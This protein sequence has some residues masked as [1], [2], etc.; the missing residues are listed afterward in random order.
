MTTVHARV[1]KCHFCGVP[2]HTIL[3]CNDPRIEDTISTFNRNVE[4]IVITIET[5]CNMD[6]AETEVDAYIDV[7]IDGWLQNIPTKLLA[8]VYR[9]LLKEPCTVRIIHSLGVKTYY[10]KCIKEAYRFK[11]TN[12]GQGDL[13]RVEL[14]EFILDY[15]SIKLV[16][17]LNDN[18]NDIDTIFGHFLECKFFGNTLGLEHVIKAIENIYYKWYFYNLN[19]VG[20]RVIEVILRSIDRIRAGEF[21]PSFDKIKLLTNPDNVDS[22]TQTCPICYD[23]FNFIDILTTQC[24]HSFCKKCVV[25]LI[26]SQSPD[27]RELQCS[28]CRENITCITSNACITEMHEFIK[29]NDVERCFSDIT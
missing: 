12:N 26:K 15:I 16:T 1:Q 9:K 19:N 21:T 17:V 3:V 20:F 2:G 5:M 23:D 8:A 6:T 27:K 13:L 18:T 4:E 14:S 10:K 11:M 24:N 29:E 22:N 28:L 25:K 7:Q